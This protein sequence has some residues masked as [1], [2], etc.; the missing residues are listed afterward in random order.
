MI[1]PERINNIKEYFN[2]SQWD[3][4]PITEGPISMP[5]IL[6]DAMRDIAIPGEYFAD[7]PAKVNVMG[8]ID[9]TPIPVIENP[10]NTVRNMEIKQRSVYPMIPGMH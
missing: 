8:M 4:Y 1:K 3:I 7:L 10:N 5:T 6:N 9:A 2:P